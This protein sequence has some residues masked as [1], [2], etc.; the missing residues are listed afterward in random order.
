MICGILKA[1]SNDRLQRNTQNKGKNTGSKLR[2]LNVN[3]DLNVN[4]RHTITK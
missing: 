2:E 3:I 1:K 4:I